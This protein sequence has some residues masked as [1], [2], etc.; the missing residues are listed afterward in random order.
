MQYMADVF[1]LGTGFSKAVCNEIPTLPELGEQVMDS[2]QSEELRAAFEGLGGDIEL[3][4]SYLSEQQPWHKQIDAYRHQADFTLLQSSVARII[5][6]AEGTATLD[7][8]WRPDWLKRLVQYWHESG[9]TVITFNYDTI[10]ER[11]FV[12]AGHDDVSVLWDAPLT[13]LESRMGASTYPMGGPPIGGSLRL[14]KPHGST[15]WFYSGRPGFPSD[16]IYYSWDYWTKRPFFDEPKMSVLASD[17]VPLIVPPVATKVGFYNLDVVQSIWRAAAS[18]LAA[19]LR[20]FV[21]G[22]SLPRTDLTV[23]YLLMAANAEPGLKR[24]RD[25]AL[26]GASQMKSHSGQRLYIVNR[27]AC[28]HAKN[29]L[30]QR[31]REICSYLPYEIDTEFLKLAPA[32]PI[33]DLVDWLTTSA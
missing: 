25:L 9:A 19:A 16:L 26:T 24:M 29:E 33:P 23:R 12:E 2:Q 5:K 13:P 27:P 17:K 14:L 32:D 31:Y 10:I 6:D 15:N 8:S 22:Y 4:M 18:R 11:A 21:L 28:A 3:L 7:D 20:V 1:V 30:I